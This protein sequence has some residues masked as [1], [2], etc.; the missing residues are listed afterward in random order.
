MIRQRFEK[1]Y[2]KLFS[3]R[4]KTGNF[5][6]YQ[7]FWEPLARENKARGHSYETVGAPDEELYEIA[8]KIL[9][10]GCCKN[11]LR[12]H[13]RILDIGCGNGRLA[14]KLERYIKPPGE[15]Y[16]IDIAETLIEEAKGKI[17]A[18]N[19][20]FAIIDSPALPFQ[21]DYFDFIVLFS[22]FTHLYHEDIIQ[23]LREIRRVLRDSGICISSIIADPDIKECEGNIAEMRHNVDFL[24]EIIGQQGLIVKSVQQS[25]H[26]G[27]IEDAMIIKRDQDGCQTCLVFS[28]IT[29]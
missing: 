16:G 13:H 19:F 11:G 7:N 25:W 12:E 9:F 23:L 4:L 15:Y 27:S 29:K 21:N 2:Q 18:S 3:P 1:L 26:S 20:K 24:K 22:V 6:E 5:D 10:M 14:V 8:G 17:I 28:R